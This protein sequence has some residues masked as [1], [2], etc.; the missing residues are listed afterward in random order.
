MIRIYMKF[1]KESREIWREM[2]EEKVVFIYC[3]GYD[4]YFIDSK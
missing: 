1:R 2:Y 3:V 4:D